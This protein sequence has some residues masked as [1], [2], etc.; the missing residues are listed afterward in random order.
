MPNFN[1]PA[2]A[3]SDYVW[4][5]LKGIMEGKNLPFGP[6]E[7]DI[8][9]AQ[10]KTASENTFNQARDTLN[11]QAAMTGFRRPWSPRTDR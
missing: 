5:Y 3:Q 10:A 1:D 9:K 6:K 11:S 4:G 7:I 2:A 8:Q